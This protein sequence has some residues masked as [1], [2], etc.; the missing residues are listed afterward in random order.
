MNQR[1]A[2]NAF[3][4]VQGSYFATSVSEIQPKNDA[5]QSHAASPVLLL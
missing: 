4:R 1:S 5:A 2:F 3:Q